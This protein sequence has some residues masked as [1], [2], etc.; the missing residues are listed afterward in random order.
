[1]VNSIMRYAV[2]LST[3]FLV[4]QSP[5]VSALS[6]D[7]KNVFDSGINYF[8]VSSGDGGSLC[9]NDLT[10]SSSKL[11]SS[12]LSKL[13]QN[14]PTYQQAAQKTN[15]PWQ[16]LAAVHY[17]ETDFSTTEPNLFQITGYSGPS[18]F[19]SQAIAAGNFL[20]NHSVPG[21]LPNHRSPLQQ[22]GTEPEEIKD[23]LYS[24][25]G[26]ASAYADQAAQLGFNKKTQPYEGS[27]YVMNDFDAIHTNMGIITGQSGPS[28]I[29]GV[30]TRLGAFTV[31]A[32][33]LG[34]SGESVCGTGSG[35]GNIPQGNSQQLSQD[36]LNSSKITF[37][38]GPN[39]YVGQPFKDLAAGKLAS[40]NE[41][42]PATKVSTHILQAILLLAQNHKVNISS[43][44]T[45]HPCGDVHT[46][47]RA[48]DINIL[49]NKHLGTGT[50]TN[51]TSLYNVPL[52]NSL[53]SDVLPALPDGSG[54]GDCDGHQIPTPG[55]NNI[56]FFPDICNH[57]HAQVPPGA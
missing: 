56:S 49:D 16:L 36:I 7:Q 26:R 19:L 5:L 6:A 25:N 1:M 33:L 4:V 14:E 28:T 52:S 50:T 8:D 13:Q 35:S 24:Y 11:S 45:G 27:P 15:V 47:G 53:M 40:N 23:T 46:V 22:S 42:C 37:D 3:V 20:Q 21:N 9:S 12:E 30:D 39:G 54:F 17:R 57:V 51:Q 43:L 41:G 48:V 34:V 38:F 44:T 55:K 32:Y 29:D 10:V 31:Y 18:D 2:F